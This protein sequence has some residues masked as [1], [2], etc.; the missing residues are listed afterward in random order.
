MPTVLRRG[1]FRAFSCSNDRNEP[2]HIHVR[3][4]RKEAK[5]WPADLDTA[6]NIGFRRHELND[7]IRKLREHCEEL[8]AAWDEHFGI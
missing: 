7:I 8:Q 5:F 2:A 6:V 1:S 3:S 4:G